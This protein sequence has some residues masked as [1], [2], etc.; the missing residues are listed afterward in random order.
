PPVAAPA[1]VAALLRRR[2][3]AWNDPRALAALYAPDAVVQLAGNPGSGWA[4]GPATIAAYLADG[5]RFA[6]AYRLEPVRVTADARVAHVAGH[7]RAVGAPPDAPPGGWFDLTLARGP[8]GAWRIV[9]E[10]PVPR[11]VPAQPTIDA[12]QLVAMLDSA[13]IRRAVVL[14]G[15]FAFGGAMDLQGAA[16][17]PE[18]R[19]A[20]VRAE[21]DW[22]AAQAARFPDR[23]VAFCAVNP[24]EPFAE[25]EVARCADARAFR[26]LKLHLDESRVDLGVP[27]HVERVRAVAAAAN[28]RA[29]PLVVHVG[30][31]RGAD[32]AAHVR[33][34]LD[35]VVGAA[36]DVPVQ[37]AH[38]WG[39]GGYS[40]GALAAFAAAVAAG[41][42]AARRLWFDV[43]EVGLM[44][45][46]AG[47]RAPALLAAAARH[48]RTIGLD[49]VLY[50]SD[51]GLIGHQTAPV[52]W[53]AFRDQV[54]LTD[55][56]L[57][58]V[59]RNVPPYLR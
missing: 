33:T 10:S 31:N 42:P 36:P 9:A 35:R 38:L 25:A 8:D 37:V 45:Q 23:L 2:E 27:A 34:F 56:E 21:N 26:G 58:R 28:A 12:A 30:N 44:M 13:R 47:P 3:A 43:A 29:L 46:H 41:D 50:G 1:D 39:G 52:A 24:L 14:S 32:A 5:R 40:E 54:P 17:T 57:W 51:G 20:R 16:D 55:A 11:R 7:L 22:T 19:R 53:A 15:A 59:A 4:R 18:R 6:R 48:M 49:R